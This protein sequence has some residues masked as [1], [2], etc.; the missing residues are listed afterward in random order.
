MSNQ[1]HSGGGLFA[2]LA[3][4]WVVTGC[5]LPA[6]AGGHDDLTRPAVLQVRNLSWEDAKVYL[7]GDGPRIRLGRV[8]SQDTER[9][10]VPA[11]RLGGAGIQLEIVLRSSRDSKRTDRFRVRPGDRV[12]LTIH[13]QLSLSGYAVYAQ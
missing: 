6:G 7:V 12:E 8:T 9:M 3:L 11:M 10:R 13:N 1:Q 2:A 5:G 4:A